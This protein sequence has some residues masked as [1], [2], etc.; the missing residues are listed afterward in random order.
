ME[1]V[2]FIGKCLYI[3]GEGK[4]ILVVG[5]LHLGFEESL[6]RSGVLVTRKM[7]EEMI[8]YFDSVFEKLESEG[9]KVEE[10]VLLGDVK[11][12]FGEILKQEWGDVLELF[13]YF[14]GKMEEKGKIVI[15][16]G[17][18]DAIL[19]PIVEKRENVFLKDYY[20]V[21]TVGFIH[22]NKK[23]EEV[24]GEDVKRLIMGHGHPAVRIS[25]GNKEE[26]YKC[27]LVGKWKGK[28]VI[29]VP[30][31]VDFKEGTDPREKDMKLAWK[32]DLEKFDVKVVSEN[33]D[34]LDFGKL[35]KVK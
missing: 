11:H 2:E 21:G 22:G 3:E 12:V 28:E 10:V 31:F 16:K 35:G 32:F 27:F 29:V 24:E 19:E 30:S 13:D 18:H 1:D 6:N 34:V 15:V 23:V 20:L 9:K 33:L 14:F 26:V 25:D 17:N 4:G 5:D 7:F 8:S